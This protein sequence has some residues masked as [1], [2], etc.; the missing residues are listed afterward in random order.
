MSEGKQTHYAPVAVSAQSTVVAEFIP[1]P[2]DSSG[3]QSEAQLEAEF[4][5]I[6]RSQAYDYLPIKTEA[7]LIANLRTQLEAVNG[8]TFSDEEWKRF[9]KELAA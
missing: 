1:E 6:L 7:D 3:Y 8:I 5:K 4:I 9:F 2:T